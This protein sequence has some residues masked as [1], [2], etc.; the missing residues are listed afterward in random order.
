MRPEPLHNKPRPPHAIEKAPLPKPKPKATARPRWDLPISVQIGEHGKSRT[1]LG[2]RGPS[3]IAELKDGVSMALT[4][5]VVFGTLAVAAKEP[6]F[7][8]STI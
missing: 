4:H 7:E 1:R 6:L 5:E 8:S 2:R 3:S